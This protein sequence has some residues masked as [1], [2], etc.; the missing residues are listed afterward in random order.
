M[1]IQVKHE[2]R[3]FVIIHELASYDT[4]EEMAKAWTAGL[5]LGSPPLQFRWVN[6]IAFVALIPPIIGDII[7]D[8]MI[9]GRL[10]VDHV[11]FAPMP[12]FKE[13]I[14]VEESNITIRIINV[15]KNETFVAMAN[16]LREKL[17][18]KPKKKSK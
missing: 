13:E 16:F 15:A 6:G 18:P 10:H 9:E 1:V 14:T 12:E 5:P 3:K 17:S 4:V 8:E 11:S 7:A 2:P